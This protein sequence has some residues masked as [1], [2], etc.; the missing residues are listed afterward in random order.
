MS[1]RSTT[2]P[3]SDV[4]VQ[5]R[6]VGKSYGDR[7]ALHR[8]DLVVAPGEVHALVGLNGAGKTTL[9]RV[10]LGMVRQDS[11]SVR[12]HGREVTDMTAADWMG[13][14]HL[15]ETPLAYP[16]LTVRQ[17]LEAAAILSGVPRRHAT[18]AI[19]SII[20]E[21]NL[22][23]WATKRTRTL[24]LGNRQRVGLAAALVAPVQLAVLDEPA[25]SLDPAG[26]VLVRDALRR[27]AQ[28][29]A[30]VL[31]S[32]HHLDEVARIATH[33]TA[34]NDGHVVGVLDPKGVDLERQFFALVAAD[35]QERETP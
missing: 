13:V 24:S 8:V 1:E 5:L 33:I 2:S 16:E 15:I 7:Q 30:A 32:S 14:G 28:Q 11:G 31:V 20:D 27:R 17:N 9:L 25:N 34:I 22:G 12:I 21:L 26:V 18:A 4:A 3:R 23:A 10:L 29:G 35:A 6:A 19:D